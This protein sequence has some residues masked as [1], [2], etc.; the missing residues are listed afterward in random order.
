MLSQQGNQLLVDLSCQ[1]HLD[2]VHGFPVRVSEAADEF[3]FD[4]QPPEHV[5]DLRAA[6]V[7]QHHLDAHQGQQHNVAHDCLLQGVVGHG[8]SPVLDHHDLA[9]VALNVGQG[10][11][12]DPGPDRVGNIL[13]EFHM[14]HS[15]LF[16][17]V[18]TGNHR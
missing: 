8:V 5:V 17:V 14:Y 18:M 11:N 15:K 1:H 7:Y 12:Q 4:V 9:V 2:H 16:D 13:W 10:V 3:A 6:S